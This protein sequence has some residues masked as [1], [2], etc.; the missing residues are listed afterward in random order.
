MKYIDQNRRTPYLLAGAGSMLLCGVGDILLSFRGEGG[1][2][3][4]GG[5]MTLN[6]TEVP[7]WYYQ[8]SFFIGIIAAVGYRLGA[9]AVYSCA[10]DR[11][12]GRP[13]KLV[14]IYVAGADMMS[15]GLFGIHSICCMA[16]MGFR[17]A[18]EA[19]LDPAAIDANFVP[20]LLMPFVVGTLW[21]T[22]ADLLVGSMYIV[23]VFRRV[24]DVPKPLLL[25]GPLC[26]YV[27]FGLLRAV[28]TA[29]S[30]SDLPGK[31]LSGGESWGLAMMFLCVA[32]TRSGVRN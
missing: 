14:R 30:G 19:G 3:A 16:V 17:A 32:R 20:A 2:A 11:M 7:L 27:I 13:G 9:C 31:F 12:G 26:L 4:V 22:I 23:L 18:A 10:C 28:L 1:E 8:L 29:V 21:Q 25:C 6:I 24:L 15:L 5:M